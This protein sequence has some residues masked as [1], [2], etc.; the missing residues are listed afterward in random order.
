MAAPHHLTRR[1]IK[2]ADVFETTLQT[3]GTWLQRYGV[4]AALIVAA[5]LVVLGAIGGLR[6]YRETQEAKAAARLSEGLKAFRG[7]PLPGGVAG[8]RDP[9]AAL[10]VFEEV[11]KDY[12]SYAAGKLAS[13]YRALALE[14]L[15]RRDEALAALRAVGTGSAEELV[16][17]LARFRLA[18]QLRA[19]GKYQEALQ[20]YQALELEQSQ[21]PLPQDVILF[22]LAR[23]EEALGRT[24]QAADHYQKLIDRFSSSALREEAEARRSALLGSG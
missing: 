8:A 9:R 24:Q 16:P 2:R 18:E 6:A 19:E 13:Y 17:A 10:A 1:E 14:N 7:Q 4:K 21:L 22:G 12:S 20:A 3:A 5:V 23:S 15:G 11:A